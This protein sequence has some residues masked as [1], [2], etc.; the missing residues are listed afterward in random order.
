MFICLI[1]AAIRNTSMKLGTTCVIH[2]LLQIPNVLRTPRISSMTKRINVII[3]GFHA[4]RYFFLDAC[5]NMDIAMNPATIESTTV[6]S[7]VIPYIQSYGVNIIH[8][9]GFSVV[10]VI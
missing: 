1:S 10:S 2:G 6:A 5:W 4:A 3:N 9:F 8:L 7:C